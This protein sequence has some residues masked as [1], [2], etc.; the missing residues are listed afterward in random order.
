MDWIQEVVRFASG[1]ILGIFS[2]LMWP[3]LRE[4]VAERKEK[5]EMKERKRQVLQ[6]LDD[7]S[8]D[9]MGAVRV[10]PHGVQ[11]KDKWVARL[12]DFA[13]QYDELIGPLAGSVKRI[14]YKIEDS[15]FDHENL[16]DPPYCCDEVAVDLALLRLC[17]L[18]LVAEER[19]WDAKTVEA[20]EREHLRNIWSIWQEIV[21]PGQLDKWH[22]R[23]EDE[24]YSEWQ[25]KKF[26]VAEK[27]GM[28]TYINYERREQ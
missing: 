18:P 28:A 15:T 19:G 24:W 10:E 11:N 3:L 23:I 12:Q 7:I 13:K 6:H 2:G 8:S 25:N 4:K 21:L 1:F 17:I 27:L 16:G 14:A 22:E 26:R 9:I 20:K 5:K